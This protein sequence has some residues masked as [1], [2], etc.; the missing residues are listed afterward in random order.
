MMSSFSVLRY[1][2]KHCGVGNLSSFLSELSKSSSFHLLAHSMQKLPNTSCKSFGP[3][4][5][6][7]STPHFPIVKNSLSPT[8]PRPGAIIPLSL[9]FSS[10]PAIQISTP[11]SHSDAA[12]TTPLTAPRTATTITFLTPHSLKV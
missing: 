10:M 5:V 7:R 8:S 9:R 12:F 6:T 2:V 3:Q 1:T 4:F 11:S